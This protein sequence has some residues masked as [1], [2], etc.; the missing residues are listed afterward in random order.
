MSRHLSHVI[1]DV[2]A[3]DCLGGEFIT[4]K[5]AL[6]ALAKSVATKPPELIRTI[7][8]AYAET[9]VLEIICTLDEPEKGQVL[10]IWTGGDQSTAPVRAWGLRDLMEVPKEPVTRQE[11]LQLSRAAV[12]GDSNALRFMG[13]LRGEL[14]AILRAIPER[15]AS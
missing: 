15:P 4:E 14:G 3:V 5:A 6:E 11:L 1:D 9:H 12:A 2:L 13:Q 7:A 10:A 8:W